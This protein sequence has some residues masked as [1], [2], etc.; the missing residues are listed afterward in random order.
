MTEEK[1]SAPVSDN[2]LQAYVDGS[3][4]QDRKAEIDIRLEQD[5]RLASRVAVWARQNETVR[6]LYEHTALEDVP[7][8]LSVYRIDRQIRNQRNHFWRMATAAVVLVTVSGTGG[9]FG[10]A[11]LSDASTSS[12]SLVSEAVAAHNLYAREIVHPVE[13][14]ADHEQHLTAWLSKRLDRALAIPDLKSEGLSLL[15]GRLL[16]ANGGPAA[17]LMYEDAAGKRVTLFVTPSADKQEGALQYASEG[18]LNSFTWTDDAVTCTIVG[19]LPRDQLQ[20]I[21]AAA[22]AQFE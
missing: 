21:A 14:S 22:Y 9:W 10:R 1:V 15:G 7:V 17:Q 18:N 8:R 6:E 3:L 13:V 20:K 5:P 4:A 11:V 12:F 16:P 19:G 2:E